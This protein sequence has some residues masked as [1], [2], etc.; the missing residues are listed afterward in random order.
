M[1]KKNGLSNRRGNQFTLVAPRLGNPAKPASPWVFRD[2]YTY[3]LT[4]RPASTATVPPGFQAL[5]PATSDHPF[6]TVTYKRPP[7]RDALESYE[8]EPLDP[9]DPWVIRRGLQTYRDQVYER[10]S[11]TNGYEQADSDGRRVTLSY[12]TRAG[13]E[14]QITY[15]LPDWTPTGHLDLNDFDEAVRALWSAL[16]KEERRQRMVDAVWRARQGNP[17]QTVDDADLDFINDHEIY[18]RIG[19]KP[20]S[21]L[22]RGYSYPMGQFDEA[23]AAHV[24]LSGYGGDGD[25]ED[26]LL[27]LDR[28]MG[29]S[30]WYEDRDRK[31]VPMFVAVYLGQ[32]RDRGP[33]GESLF[34]PTALVV[35]VPTHSEQDAESMIRRVV[36]AT[37][38]QLRS[39]SRIERR[40]N[41]AQTGRSC[42]RVGR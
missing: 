23:D 33:D 22:H 19:S 29:I 16:P 25:L 12:S 20:E 2:G 14:Y 37:A 35:A 3:A 4:R 41:P 31:R 1:V 11:D 7:P 36:L 27:D 18:V 6:G 21:D 24:G 38:R 8:L 17:A 30:G 42:R 40:R 15:W 28:R 13:V 32:Y 10:F 26:A 39:S 5:G 9:D 34:S